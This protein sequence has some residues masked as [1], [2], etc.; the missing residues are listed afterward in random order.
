MKILRV[1]NNNVVLA[2]E[3]SGGEVVLTGRGL[4]YQTRPGR[5]VDSSRVVRRFVPADQMD[6]ASFGALVAAI[7]PEHI[8][9]ADDALEVAR[10]K[11]RSELGSAALIAVADHLSFA[12]K[13]VR[14]GIVLDFPLR[15]EVAHLYPDELAAAQAMLDD[16]NARID[17]QL[18]DDE[19]VALAMHLVNAGFA[20]GNLAST[21]RMTE[22]LRQVFDIVEQSLG[23]SFD[24]QGVNAAR[25][26]THLRY[27]FVRVHEGRQLADNRTAVQDAIA[28]AYPD[29]RRTALHVA[30]MLELRLGEPVSD[31]ELTYLT[32]HV[33]RLAEAPAH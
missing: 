3:A 5:P 11:L 14:Q 18:P 23:A 30:A 9:L 7:P 15:V 26:V 12:I 22:V 27:F 25:F 20:S 6:A 8:A 17:E 21:Y 19:A 13:R 4:G 10:R 2:R 1:F 28:A 24:R 29:A 33:A 31:D 32:M 16:V